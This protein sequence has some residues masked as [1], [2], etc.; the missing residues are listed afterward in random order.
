MMTIAY[1]PFEIIGVVF[2][3]ICVWLTVRQNIMCWPT[4]LVSAFFYI[5][6]FYQV[7]LIADMGLQVVYIVLQI[8]GW[9]QWL[10]GGKD[11]GE[12]TVSRSS[13]KLNALLIAIAFAGTAS[14][15][16]ILSSRTDAALPYWDSATTVMSLIAQWMMA[17][18][19]LQCW[20]VWITVDVVS[21]G[22]Y[23]DKGLNLTLVLYTA[24]LILATL[25]YLEWKKS[26]KSPQ[27]A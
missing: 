3:L 19:Y 15:G 12:L 14:M 5:I 26:F 24:Y 10:H 23:L 6:V 27:P 11:R 7:R 9:H 13:V 17:K 20:L 8:Y 4:G 25:G 2:G 21:S 1:N 16:Y 18:K 22:K